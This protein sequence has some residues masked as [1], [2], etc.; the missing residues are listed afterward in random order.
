MVNGSVAGE[1]DKRRK[2]MVDNGVSNEDKGR[3]KGM[4]G[5]DLLM[6]IK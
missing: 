3:R 5:D 4:V 6:K 2:R 1:D